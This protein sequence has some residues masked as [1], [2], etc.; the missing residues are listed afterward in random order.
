MFR[1]NLPPEIIP[2]A[3]EF[4]AIL[5]SA[6]RA[7]RDLLNL[8][9]AYSLKKYAPPPQNQGQNGTCVAWSS[10]YAARTISYAFNRNIVNKDSIKKFAFSP[11][12]LYYKVKDAG[13]EDC[14]NGTNILKAMKVMTADGSC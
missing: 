9:I 7:T 1:H 5:K 12:Y 3:A 2:S 14:M 10:A 8:P 11:G 6:D 4:D 13:D